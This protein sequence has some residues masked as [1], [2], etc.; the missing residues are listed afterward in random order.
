VKNTLT[1]VQSIAA[2]TRRS[3]PD[4]GS[5]W[6]TFDHRVRGMSKTHDL[7]TASQWEGASLRDIFTGELDLYQDPLKQR[8]SLRGKPVKVGA[9]ATLALGLAVHEL[10]TNAAKYGSLSVPE[11]RLAVQWTIVTI[12]G[13]PHLLIEWSESQGP[14]VAPPTRRGFGSRLLQRSLGLEL[15]G[16]LKLTYEPSGLRCVITF[17]LHS[18]EEAVEDSGLATTNVLPFAR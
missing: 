2:M 12:G 1:T 16:D 17:P 4:A 13:L 18:V 11:G 14:R 3:A 5:A 7:L 15:G 6:E 9:K 10:A 8:I